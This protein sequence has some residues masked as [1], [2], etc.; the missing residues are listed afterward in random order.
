MFEF[1]AKKQTKEL[2]K[3][4]AIA[5]SGSKQYAEKNNL[6]FEQASALKIVNIKEYIKLCKEIGIKE[7]TLYLLPLETEN[8]QLFSTVMD[9]FVKFF[10]ELLLWTVMENVNVSV[11]GKWYDLPGRVID[12]IKELVQR[13]KDGAQMRV[14]LCLSY[15]G[16]EEIVDAC[17]LLARQVQ[18]GKLDPEAITKSSIKGNLYSSS[19]P[20]PDLVVRLGTPRMS[21]LLLWDLPHAKVFT[22]KKTWQEFTGRDLRDAMAWWQQW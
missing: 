1:F 2:P 14:N 6:T 3:H 19:I 12:P 8:T 7:L 20:A 5:G 17:K 22:T 15:D 9:S 18:A 4:I 11:L 10:N 21:S 13:S 16:Q